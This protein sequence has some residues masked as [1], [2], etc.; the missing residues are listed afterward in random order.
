MAIWD[1]WFGRKPIEKAVGRDEALGEVGVSGLDT[2]TGFVIEE[3]LPQLRGLRSARVYREMGDNDP[4][5]GSMLFLID[6]IVRQ[7]DWLVTPASD[8]QRDL[9]AA[10]FLRECM[11]DM[12]HTWVA[13]ISE[14]MTMVQYGWSWVETVYK[15]RGG[16]DTDDPT[17]KSKFTDGRIGW[18][19]HAP[20]SQDTLWRWEFDED[21]GIQAMI[22]QAPPDYLPRRIPVEKSMLFRT[23]IRK[24]NPEG[25]S[26][27]RNAYRP[28]FFKKRMEEIEAIGTERDLAGMPVVK[29]PRVYLTAK[30]NAEQRSTVATMQ[31]LVTSIRR[32]SLEGVVFPSE[33]DENGN[34][35]FSL[36]LLSTGGRRQF[37]TDKMINRY[38]RRIAMVALAD[39]ILLGQE[40]V[41]SFALSSSKTNMFLL[42]LQGFLDE[43]KEVL[44]RHAVPCLFDLN[45]FP[46]EELPKFEYQ[47]VEDLDIKE[48]VESVLA[49]ANAGAPLFP[50][51][52]L[53]NEIRRKLGLSER[54]PDET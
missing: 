39:F 17:R 37:D 1:D 33:R 46:I 44:N 32:D 14:A 45:T 5:I 6:M 28:W 30:A 18:R 19:K 15:I 29:V 50:D 7:V 12:N 24:N 34:D 42:A 35:K 31:N 36:E 20:R 16:R 52:I 13:F 4:I 2:R 54:I 43:I 23:T 48:V 41:G 27:L 3:F 10:E 21:G 38:D 40:Q 22:Q 53:E 51:D 26:V 47:D 11:D 49:L 9:D 8:D 25:K